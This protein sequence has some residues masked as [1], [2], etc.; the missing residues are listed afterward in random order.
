MSV[1]FCKV[2]EFIVKLI[3]Q[4]WSTSLQYTKIG[5]CLHVLDVYRKSLLIE[6]PRKKTRHRSP[7]IHP[8]DGEGEIIRSA[9]ELHE[10]GI[11]F[12][13][14]KSSSLKDISFH[15]GVLRLPLVVVDD[16]TEPMF[17][18]LIAFERFHIGAGNDVTSYIFLMD[19]IIDNARDVVLLHSSGIIQNAIGSD[20]AVAKL[21]NTLSKDV[22]LDPE[23]SL[24]VVHKK[25]N[26]YC[27]KKWN[28]WRANLMHTYFTSPWASLS[29]LAAIIL[30]GLTIVQTWF[31]LHPVQ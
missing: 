3:M 4:F 31:T 1:D 30:F 28:E 23:C 21:F 19:N 12:K 15:G 24:N 7:M 11:R 2:D 5:K 26:D 13:K 27:K 10:A 20:K 22:T 17:L 6:E 18:N 25:V 8:P 16:M 9:T 14:S 29:V